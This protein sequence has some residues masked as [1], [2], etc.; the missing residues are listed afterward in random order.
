[1]LLGN[2]LGVLGVLLSVLH[3]VSRSIGHTSGRGARAGDGGDVGGISESMWKKARLSIGRRDIAG[4]SQHEMYCLL[5][6]GS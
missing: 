5:I 6:V 2:L 1:M 3:R 4:V